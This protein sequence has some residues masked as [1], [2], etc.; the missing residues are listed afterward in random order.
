M[1]CLLSR[2]HLVNKHCPIRQSPQGDTST[3]LIRGH[4][5][6]ATTRSGPFHWTDRFLPSCPCDHKV[7]V[8]QR[9]TAAGLLAS[10][11]LTSCSKSDA[12]K[13]PPAAPSGLPVRAAL[14]AK[15]DMPVEIQ[16]I[17]NVE[18]YS[19]VTLKSRIAAQI[20]RV[21]LRDGQEA[22][23]GVQ[24]LELHPQAFDDRVR[25]AEAN[26]CQHQALLSSA[27]ANV[28]RGQPQ[29]RHARAQADR[30]E[31]LVKD[32]ITSNDLQEQVRT[33]AEAAV[34]SLA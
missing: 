34:A 12:L 19:S 27:E 25:K 33:V 1:D 23:E 31:A 14:G 15:L 7:S 16:A 9:I 20:L 32:G 8:C 21:H 11:L 6:R 4:Y 3:E 26:L 13:G 18:A 2:L 24:W 22:R 17:G 30:Y 5:H 10:L 28:V 29:A